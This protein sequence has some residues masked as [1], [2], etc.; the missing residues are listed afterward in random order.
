MY[1]KRVPKVGGRAQTDSKQLAS[2]RPNYPAII[3]T[4]TMKHEMQQKQGM[5][6]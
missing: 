2:Y 6:D 3:H 5:E 1:R 4:T